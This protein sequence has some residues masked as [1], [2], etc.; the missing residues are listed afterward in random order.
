MRIAFLVPDTRGQSGWSRYARDLGLALQRQGH[1]VIALVAEQAEHSWCREIRCLAPAVHDLNLLCCLR[2]ALRLH[3]AL[4]ALKPDIVHAIAEP[5]GMAL[6]LVPRRPWR[7]FLTLHG[8]YALAPLSRGGIVRWLFLRA[9]RVCTQVFAVSAFTRDAV[10]A[11]APTLPAER[12]DVLHNCVDLER[13]RFIAD[14]ANMQKSIIGVG[15]VKKRKGYL[16]AVDAI[17]AARRAGIDCRYDI[18][19]STQEDPKYV[20]LLRERIASLSL[21][22]AVT[23]H[24]TVSD[25]VLSQAYATADAFLLLSLQDGDNVEGF[26]IVFLEANAWGV[27]VVGPMTGGCPEAIDEGR[28]GYVCDPYQPQ[29]VAA[30]LVSILRDGAIDR[31]A[32]RA[33]AEQHSAASRANA[34]LATYTDGSAAG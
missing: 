29:S 7:C 6:A 1:E 30:C 26:G 20:A 25:D 22:S 14:T 19:G 2:D 27:P 21:D 23:L 18:Y 13:S 24:G 28:T 31:A 32:C 3:A 15:A 17:A 4:F 16:E 12:I 34:L 11:R 33:W 10:L 5:Y 8:T 9:V